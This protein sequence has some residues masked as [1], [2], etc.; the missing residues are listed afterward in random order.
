M[1]WIRTYSRFTHQG[2]RSI[3]V[4]IDPSLFAI[5]VNSPNTFQCS[6]YDSWAHNIQTYTVPDGEFCWD[7]K[8]PKS[9]N[10]ANTVCE[11]RADDLNFD[12]NDG[13]GTNCMIDVK[14]SP[15]K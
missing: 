9:P 14:N 15:G 2:R 3:S 12:I 7:D 5:A 1:I 11:A 10:C 6:A 13:E 4:K 8:F